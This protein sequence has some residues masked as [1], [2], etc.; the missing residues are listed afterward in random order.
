MGREAQEIMILK[1]PYPPSFD[2][3]QLRQESPEES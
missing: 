3:L 1:P 2:V